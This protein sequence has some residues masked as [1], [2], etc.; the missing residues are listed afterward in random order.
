MMRCIAVDDEPLALA[1]VR[2]NISRIPFLNLVGTCNDVFEAMALLEKNQIDLIFVDIHMPRLSGLE[3]I[4]SLDNKPLVIFITAYE[5]YALQSY[6]LD[7]VDYLVK[8][9]A[10]ER[11]LRACHR[12]KKIF[13]LKIGK[14]HVFPK[15]TKDHFFVNS[16]HSL[17][18]VKFDDIIWLQG[19]GDYVKF[20]L[21]SVEFPLVVR[22]T[23]KNLESEL[24]DG[25]FVRI[26]RS[27]LVSIDRISAV[28]K[29]TVFLGDKE[30]VIGETYRKNVEKLIEK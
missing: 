13:E 14:N 27:Y 24:P 30:F 19:Y 3:Y 23:F 28:R 20:Y 15:Q 22:T 25:Q 21:K 29:S 5:E 4:K 6:D 2:D 11:F 12:A 9:V 7:I 10:M 18:K 26:H 1:L 17:V 8:P 16:K